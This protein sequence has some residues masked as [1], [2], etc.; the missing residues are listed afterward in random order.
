MY[1]C[2]HVT[3]GTYEYSFMLSIYDITYLS[4]DMKIILFSYKFLLKPVS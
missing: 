1:A 3:L 4:Y 2:V